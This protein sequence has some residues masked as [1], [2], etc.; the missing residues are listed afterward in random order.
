MFKFLVLSALALTIQQSFADTEVVRLG[1]GF[2]ENTS[3][4]VVF[5]VPDTCG[6]HSVRAVVRGDSARISAMFIDYAATGA[7]RTRFPINRTFTPGTGTA[8]KD[9]PGTIRCVTR[10]T[11]TGHSIGA[12]APSR[13]D[14]YGARERG[15]DHAKLIGSVQLSEGR[16]IE[17]KDVPNAC[18]IHHVRLL[19][20]NDNARIEYV[21]VRFGNG[22]FQNINVRENFAIN[23][24]SAWKD[25]NGGNRC[26]SAFMVFGRSGA[27][28]RDALVHLIGQ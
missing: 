13:V 17:Y 2:L 6:I 20:T 12:A 22:E 26:I 25:L 15:N 14:V 23:S 18:N 24:W 10:V 3:D 9:L 28:P 7:D 1:S 5:D 27:H 8:W 11:I 21:A 16:S 4:R 19:V